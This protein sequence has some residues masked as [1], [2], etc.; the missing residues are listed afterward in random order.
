MLTFFDH[1]KKIRRPPAGGRNAL[2]KARRKLQSDNQAFDRRGEHPKNT[3]ESL[4]ASNY[5]IETNS[6]TIVPPSPC[7]CS[8]FT[9]AATSAAIHE[10]PLFAMS[11]RSM[12][13]AA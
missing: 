7:T 11:T 1:T 9:G 2:S 13:F 4:A 3:G 8:T 10:R 6:I 12:R 5:R